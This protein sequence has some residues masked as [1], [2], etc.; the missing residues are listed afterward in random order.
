MPW[1]T[2]IPGAEADHHQFHRLARTACTGLPWVS[3]AYAVR[4]KRI[5]ARSVLAATGRNFMPV[6]LTNSSN[7]RNS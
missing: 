3:P 2:I 7:A 5:C 4:S 1:P 6:V